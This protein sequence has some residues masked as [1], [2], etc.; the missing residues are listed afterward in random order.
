MALQQLLL[1]LA[2]SLLPAAGSAAAA[3]APSSSWPLLSPP[4][5][6]AAESAD[7]TACTRCASDWAKV[8][9]VGVGAHNQTDLCSLVGTCASEVAECDF[10]LQPDEI[11]A[12]CKNLKNTSKPLPTLRQ[13]KGAVTGRNTSAYYINQTAGS[14]G[15]FVLFIAP[16]TGNRPGGDYTGWACYYLFSYLAT[17]GIAVF[18]ANIP[19]PYD[20]HRDNWNRVP[21]Q[22][23][24]PYP[25]K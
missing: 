16:Q 24:R 8:N 3:A 19:D 12:T 6:V 7:K 11:F 17:Q 25:Y 18:T 15:P 20:M 14:N 5:V 23:E 2:C 9:F 21:S 1:S 13:F 10:N 22:G 4:L